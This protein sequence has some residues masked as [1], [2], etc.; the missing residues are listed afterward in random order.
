MSVSVAGM[1]NRLAEEES[2]SL[3][4]RL[5]S[6][7]GFQRKMLAH[8]LQ[9]PALQRLVYSTCS[10]HKEENEDVVKDVLE[11][12][13]EAFRYKKVVK[14]GSAFLELVELGLK[15]GLGLPCYY[16]KDCWWKRLYKARSL[17]EISIDQG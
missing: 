12:E 11:Q 6:L 5:Q 4:T 17:L 16:F 13:G 3:P 2:T 8:A 14:P 1:V 15:S 9:F 7:A 10:V